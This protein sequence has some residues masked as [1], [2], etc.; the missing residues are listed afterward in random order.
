MIAGGPRRIW[1]ALLTVLTVTALSG[2]VSALMVRYS[3]G[4]GVDSTDLD[5][6]LSA[7]T[8][9]AIHE[10]QA[11]ESNPLRFYV[12]YLGGVLRGDFGTSQSFQQPIGDLLADRAPATVRLVL[13]GTS[14]GWL[15]AFSLAALTVHFRRPLWGAG[16][17][18]ITGVLLAVP[19]SVFALLFYYA[20][21]PL[22]VAVGIMLVPRLYGTLRVLLESL[23]QSDL[24]IAA[25]AR[26]LRR[27]TLGVH[28]FLQLASGQL[29]SLFGIASV[30]AFGF[31]VPIEALCD[32]P[33]IG[34]LAWKAALSRDMPLLSAIALVVTV[35]VATIHTAGELV[36][37]EDA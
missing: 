23:S 3:P 18:T 11:V 33:G 37:R 36:A 19:P 35:F 4:Y 6:R 25:R 9:R 20:D 16:A 22:T 17:A 10:R 26:G 5:P 8:V 7:E 32:H 12:H 34:Q 24:L 28:Y 27:G 13:L 15:W 29:A 14:A 31:A 2:L 21:A 30:I 1:L